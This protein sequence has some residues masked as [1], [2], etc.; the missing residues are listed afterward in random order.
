MTFTQLL[1]LLRARRWP[2]VITLVAT[3]AVAVLASV[4][5][6][7]SY[8]ASATLVLNIKGVD[9]VSGLPLPA[10]LTGGYLATQ[11]DI[12]KSKN[13]ALRVVDGLKLAASAAVQERFRDATDGEGDIRDWLAE[14]LLKK[15]E[16]LPARESSVIT[17]TFKGSDPQ[18]V[19]TVAN[20]FAD[21]YQ[22]ATIALKVEPLKK[23]STYINGQIKVLRDNLET[24]QSNLSKY[25]QENGIVSVD[26]RLDVETNRLNELSSQLV[27]A[28]AQRMDAASRRQQARGPNAAESPDV[29]ANPLIQNLKASLAQAEAKFSE[30]SEKLGQNHPV[31]RSTKAE[32]DQLRAE[33]ANQVRATSNS[34]GNT[35]AIFERREAELRA[36]LQ[37]Q[38]AKV[39]ELNRARDELSVRAKDVENAQRAYDMTTQRFSQTSLEGQANQTEVAILNQA[40][41]P[42]E[43]AFPKL[44][45]NAVLSLFLGTMLGIGVGVIAELRDRRVRSV[46]DLMTALQAPVLGAV[47]RPRMKTRRLALP[48]LLTPRRLRLN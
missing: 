19:A 26:T 33:L 43:A 10:Q 20:A 4:L 42:F 44:Y 32:L 6:P 29:A 12:I 34:V 15:L 13:V 3:V 47:L 41:A 48:K 11:L 28:Q 27:Q 9:A 31:Y 37:A 35:A 40:V 25:Q 45:L 21:E 38:K 46:E 8:K 23:A 36:A 14:A 22:R 16:V 7:K 17:I 5:L 18:F 1:L 24:A 30:T 39:L 2:I